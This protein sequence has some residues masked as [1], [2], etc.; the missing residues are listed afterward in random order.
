MGALCCGSP[1]WCLL[2][3]KHRLLLPPHWHVNRFS[4]LTSHLFSKTCSKM[5]SLQLHWSIRHSW[6]HQ[7]L[8]KLVGEDRQ[9]QMTNTFSRSKLG[10]LYRLCTVKVRLKDHPEFFQNYDLRFIQP[11]Y[12]SSDYLA[13]PSPPVIA[14]RIHFPRMFYRLHSTVSC[15]LLLYTVTF[16]LDLDNGQHKFW[17]RGSLA[18]GCNKIHQQTE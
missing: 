13:N 17:G 9:S 10:N 3:D 7:C 16:F 11:F 15:I 4:F 1:V 18:R 5:M 6:T 14:H 8:E 12:F 2:K